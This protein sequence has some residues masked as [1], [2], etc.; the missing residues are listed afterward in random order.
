MKYHVIDKSNYYRIVWLLHTAV[1]VGKL[2]LSSHKGTAMNKCQT[3]YVTK[4][5]SN[6]VSIPLLRLVKFS[7]H[8]FCN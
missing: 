3:S 5:V 2:S 1:R 6:E 4:W 8:L 7:V